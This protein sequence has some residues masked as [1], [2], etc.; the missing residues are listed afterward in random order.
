MAIRFAEAG[1]IPALM[2]VRA[3]V[4]ENRLRSLVIA[5]TDYA[6]YVVDGRCWV[7]AE[8]EKIAGFSAIEADGASLWALFV[9]PEAEGV[10][11]GRALLDA[12]IAAAQARGAESIALTTEAGSRAEAFYRR[13]GFDASAPD[14]ADEVRMRFRL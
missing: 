1:D 7:W 6:P 8:H 3:S 4:T 13:Y 10:G 9:L 12:A 5:P 11:V 2:T 14:A